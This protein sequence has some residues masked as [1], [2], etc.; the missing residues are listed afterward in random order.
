MAL[1]GE[2]RNDKV[3][4]V[5]KAVQNLSAQQLAALPPLDDGDLR[6]FG[7]IVQ[8]FGFIDLNLRRAVEIFYIAKRLPE[9][10][11]KAFPNQQDGAL[12]DVLIE[13]VEAME[14]GAE[15]V[16]TVDQLRAIAQCRNFRNLVVH[17]AAKRFPGA[18][19]FVFASKND[20]DARKT[21]GRTLP[22]HRVQMAVAGRG[23]FYTMAKGLGELQTWLAMKV[24]EWDLRYLS[25]PPKA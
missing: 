6:L 20:R 13:V 21:L 17:S 14:R 11:S 24:P 8:H 15:P 12:T 1:P 22:Q 3:T 9:L 2:F 5:E 16:A 4:A 7:T 19:V 18:D 23:E 10:A 25:Q